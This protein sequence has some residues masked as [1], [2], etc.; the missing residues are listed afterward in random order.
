MLL[1]TQLLIRFPPQALGVQ[2]PQLSDPAGVREEQN[3]GRFYSQ[4]LPVQGQTSSPSMERSCAMNT[5]LD[6]KG[7]EFAL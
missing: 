1:Q 2:L 3:I 7:T 5:C 6:N 4:S